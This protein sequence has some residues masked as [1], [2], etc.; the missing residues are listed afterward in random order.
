MNRLFDKGAIAGRIQEIRGALEMRGKDFAEKL[1]VSG[2]SQSEI[3]GGKYLPNFEYIVSLVQVFQVNLYYLMFGEGE[4]FAKMPEG[5]DLREMEK[6]SE[7]NK[8][9]KKFLYYF[10]RSTIARYHVLL[11]FNTKYREARHA[12]EQEVEEYNKEVEPE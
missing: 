1:G 10:V 6:L 8:D 5:Y 9:V 4:M 11:E 3:E 2:P 12:I 7:G